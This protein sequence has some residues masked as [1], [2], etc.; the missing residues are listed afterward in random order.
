MIMEEKREERSLVPP[1]PPLF[2]RTE[3]AS[4]VSFKYTQLMAPNSKKIA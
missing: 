1:T 3:G 2:W 4:G